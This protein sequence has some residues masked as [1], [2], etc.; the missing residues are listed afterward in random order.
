MNKKGISI[1]IVS[2]FFGILIFIAVFSGL[3]KFYADQM[4]SAN[5]SGNVSI[6]NDYNTSYNNVW[7]KTFDIQEKVQNIRDSLNTITDAQ[8]SASDIFVGGLTGFA[9]TIWLP[10]SLITTVLEIFNLIVLPFAAIPEWALTLASLAILVLL[11]YAVARGA[12][13]RIEL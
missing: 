13:G 9:N 1:S 3:F 10:I 4:E 12:T 5:L 2:V 11:V 8:S 7:N 6:Y